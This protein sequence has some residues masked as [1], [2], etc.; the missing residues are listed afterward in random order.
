MKVGTYFNNF[1]LDDL[2]NLV[3]TL[4]ILIIVTPKIYW[5]D[6]YIIKIFRTLKAQPSLF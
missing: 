5:V 1:R 4:K 3:I 2:S 6:P